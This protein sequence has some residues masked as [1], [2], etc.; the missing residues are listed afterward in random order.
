MQRKKRLLNRLLAVHAKRNQKD[1]GLFLGCCFNKTIIRLVPVGY[2]MIIANSTLF[3][4]HVISNARS[5][6][7]CVMFTKL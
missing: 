7:S 2:E 4:Y 3:I 5:W 6:N 1:L